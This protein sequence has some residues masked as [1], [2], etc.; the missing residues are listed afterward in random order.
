MRRV[1]GGRLEISGRWSGVRGRRFVRPTLTLTVGARAER[2]RWLAEL[3][4]KPWSANDGDLWTAAF[5]VDVD[6]AG[7]TEI[8]LSVAPDIAVA[9]QP[10]SDDGPAG[11]AVVLA[12]EA[13]TPRAKAPPDNRRPARRARDAERLSERLQAAEAALARER[14][15][16]AATDEALERER[17]E[18][19]HL[20]H[21]LG[22]ARAEL[23][24]ARAAQQEAGSTTE[25]LDTARRELLAAD[26]RYERLNAEQ[27][28]IAT[29][30][31]QLES[32]LR[33]RAEELAGTQEELKRQ[34]ARVAEL[35]R[36]RAGRAR[37]LE[38]ARE[39]QGELERAPER[40]AEASAAGQRDGE[41]RRERDGESSRTRVREAGPR[42]EREAEPSR[43]RRGE[44]EALPPEPRGRT[45]P[46]PRLQRPLNPALAPRPNWAR[47]V[48][49][50]LV[51]AAV[52][53]AIWL[54]LHSTIL[55]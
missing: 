8:E 6:L 36:E 46:V 12:A 54:V 13:R 1:A 18:T 38:R 29:A 17:A 35:E 40:T 10:P 3:E 28:R 42:R 2:R 53:V 50:L 31:D 5:P 20:G 45:A 26:R 37:E 47:R 19:R 4:H 7:T 41:S 24:L 34:R 48:L 23:D 51:I 30:R 27:D 22:R 33:D 14:E 21:E 49:A 44:D 52:I 32:E 15:R 25:E 43:A 39:R 9:L 11:R 16:R 55:H